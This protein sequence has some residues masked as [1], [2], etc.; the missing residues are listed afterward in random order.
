MKVF[1]CDHCG[2]LLFFENF[3]CMSCH[4]L[5]AYVPELG[6]VCSLDPAGNNE[7]TSPLER[8][9]GMRFRL[10]RNYIRHNTCNWA[11]PADDPHALCQACRLTHTIPN[12]DNR[13]NA[14][15]WY[16][17]GIAKRRLIY[18][19]QQ[20]HLPVRSKLDD[21]ERGLEFDFL[22]DEAG[23]PPVLT[24]HDNGRIVVNI[25]E[26]DEVEREK[27]RVSMHE[28]YRTLLG[29]FRHEIGHYYWDVLIA[30]SDRLTA[31]RK[32]FGDERPD[33]THALE[34]HYIHGPPENWQNSYVSAYATA[35]PWEDWAETWAHYLH[36][37]D[38]LETA[39]DSGVRLHPRR[40]DEPAL[41]EVVNP[42]DDADISFDR[43][44]N[45]WLPL[46]YVL[47]N[48]NRGLGMS[49][50]YP[51]VLSEPAMDK[52]RFVHETVEKAGKNARPNSESPA[53]AI[54]SAPV[55]TLAE[56]P[57]G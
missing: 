41:H 6:V 3:H 9:A 38:T 10:C 45:A 31:F 26:A 5:L 7:W 53:D 27:R 42:I 40:R 25:I 15:L 13:E 51:F 35:H 44:M 57:E 48:L 46:T 33:Y 55:P 39:A 47:N 11:M 54:P 24:G 22:A 49:D 32:L 18:T 28:P 20:L 34:R 29:H 2:Q 4:H 19:L 8:A 17:L 36:V 43:M 37:T 12:L 23:L 30:N 50:A 21:P 56:F 14:V 1:H 52:L 16:R